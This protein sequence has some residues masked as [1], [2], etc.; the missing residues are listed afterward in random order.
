VDSATQITATTPAGSAGAASVLVTTPGGTNAA[1]TL[2]TYVAPPTVTAISP[3]SGSTAGGTSVTITGTGFT[4]ATAVTIGGTAVT[5]FSV[6]NATTIT[7]VTPAGSAGAAS[8]LVTSPDGT[9]AA[10]TLFTYVAPPTVTAITP[11]TGSAYGGTSVT[12]TGTD[13]TG[14]TG[15]SIG[16]TAAT[17]V[18]VS[19][20]TTLT[21]I[22]PAGSAGTASVLVTTPGGTNAANT[23]YTYLTPPTL[24]WSNATPMNAGRRNATSTLLNDGQVLIIG[25]LSALSSAERYNPTTGTSTTIN[26]LQERWAHCSEKLPDGRVLVM[27]GVPSPTTTEIYDPA[28]GAFTAGP[29]LSTGRMAS[30]STRLSNGK[31]LIYGSFDHPYTLISTAELYDP[32]TNTWTTTPATALRSDAGLV[33]LANG[34]A[35]LFG[36]RNLS[37]GYTAQRESF[38]YDSATNTWTA[39]GLLNT[40]TNEIKSVVLPNGKILSVGDATNT[41]ELYD[42]ATGVWTNTG[43]RALPRGNGALTLLGDGRVLYA[44]GLGSDYRFP[45]TSTEIYNPS[46]GTWSAGPALNTAR[47]F[48][49]LNTLND[50]RAMIAAGAINNSWVVTTSVEILDVANSAPTDIALSASSIAENNAANATVGTLSA[51]DVDAANTHT[52]TLVSGTGSTDNASFTIDGSALKLTPVADFE[53]KSSYSVRVQAS[54]GLG[55]TFAKAFTITITDVVE[56]NA[57]LSALTLSSGTLDPAFSAATTTYTALVSNSTASITVTPTREAAIATIQVRINSGSYATVTSGAASSALSLNIGSNTVEVLVTSQDASATKTYAVTVTRQSAAQ[58]AFSS[59]LSTFATSAG[60]PANAAPS[61]DSDGDGKTNLEEFAFGTN[62]ASNSSGTNALSYT[63][64][65][66]AATP[67]ATGQPVANHEPSA[68]GTDYRAVFMRRTDHATTGLT[69]TVQFSA[70]MSTWS[71]S[72]ATPTVLATSGD[73]QL[74]T[75]RYPLFVAGRPARFFRIVVAQP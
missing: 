19:N 16:G 25:G 20:A 65:F 55:G 42:P 21:C 60:L 33:P 56:N 73:Y 69:Y 28:T 66:A 41:C 40:A 52:F 62:P 30:R 70:N 58:T 46:T 75:V 59:A 5:S 17:S 45:T 68:T 54:D 14:A 18:V 37:T 24:A 47:F 22:T 44:G 31:V 4:G 3:T 15:V 43:N 26:M 32:A 13:F 7:A 39:S 9:N 29:S 1:N 63:G 50:G 38:I 11:A 51:T 48:P 64:T 74:V 49:T 67:Q 72:A 2:F 36:G 57:N 71:T 35:L 61:T 8:V 10:N 23:L 53:T 27:G 34:K 6:T 12:I